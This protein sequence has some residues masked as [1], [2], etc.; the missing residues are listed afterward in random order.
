MNEPFGKKRRVRNDVK[1]K[2]ALYGPHAQAKFHNKS[3]EYEES[4]KLAKNTYRS[5]DLGSSPGV[6]KFDA[7]GTTVFDS[8]AALPKTVIKPGKGK[9]SKEM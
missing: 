4:P 8:K 9:G 7:T 2:I 1:E 6:S 5:S 3:R